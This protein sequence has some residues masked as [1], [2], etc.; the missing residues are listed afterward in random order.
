MT[1]TRVLVAGSN[2][3]TRQMECFWRMNGDGSID[4]I[5]FQRF[6]DN[7][8][9]GGDKAGVTLARAFKLL[10]EKKVVGM[11]EAATVRG[12]KEFDPGVP[13]RYSEATLRECTVQNRDVGT[14]WRL[15]PTFG[16]SLRELREQIGTDPSHQPCCYPNNWW[17]EKKED[18][19]ATKKPETGYWLIDFNGRFARTSW[20]NQECEIAKLGDG[21]LRTPEAVIAEAITTIF[22]ITNE[23]LLESW[24]H[25]GPSLDSGGLLVCVGSFGEGGWDGVSDALPDYA[26]YGDL[27]VCIARKFQS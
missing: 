25:W 20:N 24:Y 5:R 4:G 1:R 22:Q 18:N 26:A 2:I 7:P 17:L 21:F 19:W 8:L 16:F 11:G 15:V 14:D 23:R 6:L 10:G 12:L 3:S 13:I 9:W 27:R